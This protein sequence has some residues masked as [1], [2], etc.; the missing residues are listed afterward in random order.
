MHRPPSAP[1]KIHRLPCGRLPSS[2]CIRSALAKRMRTRTVRAG[3]PDTALRHIRTDL[4][5]PSRGAAEVRTPGR[6]QNH[7]NPTSCRNPGFSRVQA[8]CVFPFAAPLQSVAAGSPSAPEYASLPCPLIPFHTG[9]SQIHRQK[10]R[11]A[12]QPHRPAPRPNP[13]LCTKSL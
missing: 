4:L 7:R 6:E 11:K 10:P 3:A 1:F 2:R 13:Q 5:G 9:L 12:G 8:G